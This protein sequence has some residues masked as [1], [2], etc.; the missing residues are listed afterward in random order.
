M[1]KRRLLLGC[2]CASLALFNVNAFCQDI[3]RQSSNNE[4]GRY[5]FYGTQNAMILLDT[6]TGKMWK[7]TADVVGKLK[8]EGATVEG[9]AYSSSDLET[10]TAKLKE[11]NLE[12]V[13]EKDK[14]QCMNELIAHFSYALDQEKVAKILKVY[15]A[16][17]E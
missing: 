2:L 7:I 6:R 5:Q 1:G 10:L 8:A 13:F 14:K 11:V 15:E 3:S 4:I 17:K 12:N 9:I 16:K